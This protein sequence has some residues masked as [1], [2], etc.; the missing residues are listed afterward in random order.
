MTTCDIRELS[1]EELA[2]VSGGAVLQHETPH[3]GT[4]GLT[5]CH[6]YDDGVDLPCFAINGHSAT[7]KHTAGAR[8]HQACAPGTEVARLAVLDW[9]KRQPHGA[10]L[11]LR[12]RREAALIKKRSR[13]CD[14]WV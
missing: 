5:E 4:V 1:V 6:I 7:G 3:A 8:W 9:I 14:R 11:R 12:A 10:V 2:S 13:D